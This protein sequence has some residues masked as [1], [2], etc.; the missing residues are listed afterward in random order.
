[1]KFANDRDMQDMQRAPVANATDDAVQGTS[2]EGGASKAGG[3][4]GRTE[5]E[6]ERL[7][8]IRPMRGIHCRGF[9]SALAARSAGRRFVVAKP[10]EKPSCRS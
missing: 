5:C 6:G 1:V 9:I 7:F 3:A 8:F 10:N 2:G 4:Y